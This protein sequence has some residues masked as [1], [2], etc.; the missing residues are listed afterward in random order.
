MIP[1]YQW[2]KTSPADKARI[3]RRAQA[4]MEPIQGYVADITLERI[5]VTK[6]DV[7]RAYTAVDPKVIAIMKE[8]IRISRAYAE[9]EK[10][11]LAMDW[12]IETV[13]GVV[14]GMRLNAIES[15]GLYVPA[16]KA[17]L[18]VVAQI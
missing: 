7:A 15:V 10:E 3:L 8:Q 18:S 2:N 14:T 13:P 6:E 9:A 17:P 11:Y 12:N 16:G 5:R 1:L 4:D